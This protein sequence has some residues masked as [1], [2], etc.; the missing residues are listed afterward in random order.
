[1]QARRGAQAPRGAEGEREVRLWRLSRPAV[2]A[3]R[4]RRTIFVQRFRVAALQRGTEGRD[5]PERYLVTGPRRDLARAVSASARDAR[6]MSGMTIARV[7]ALAA[8][9]VALAQHEPA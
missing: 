4:R 7:A 6:R 1:G 8:A 3:G 5:R 9:A 2:P